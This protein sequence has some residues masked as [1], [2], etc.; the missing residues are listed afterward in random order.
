MQ[1]DVTSGESLSDRLLGLLNPIDAAN[2][3]TR[4]VIWSFVLSG[5]GTILSYGLHVFLARRLGPVDYGRYTYAMG[6][7]NIALL[8]VSFELGIVSLR[9]LGTYRAHGEWGLIRGL[10]RR[11]RTV[12]L[13]AWLVTLAL[14]GLVTTLGHWALETDLQR[15]FLAAAL[16][17]PVA[18]LLQ[19]EGKFL[20]GFDRPLEARVPFDLVRP[21]LVLGLFALIV[22]GGRDAAAWE[23]VASNGVGAAVALAASVVLF[24]RVLPP[25]VKQAEP[26]YDMG[27][28]SRTALTLFA[29][30]SFQLIISQQSDVVVVGLLRDTTKAGWYSAASQL[31]TLVG[32]VAS[33]S[34]DVA[35]A[36]IASRYA[37]GD[38]V[39][40]RH[41]IQRVSL[42]NLAIAAPILLLLVF[43]GRPLLHIYG[44]SFVIAYPVLWRLG[45]SQLIAAGIGSL[46]GVVL[47]MTGKQQLAA[48]YIMG[49]ALLNLGLT[50][51]WTPVFGMIGT[52]EATVAAVALR[53]LIV[54]LLVRRHVGVAL[55]PG[56]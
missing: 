46:G 34:G 8:V 22:A 15:A 12:I 50:L 37:A 41:V 39:G 55:R 26:A 10:L 11:S 43:A 27:N 18:A 9:F 6:W 31:A 17:L 4:G 45:L 29:I 42:L 28:W 20:Q 38:P 16:V 51:W 23:A 3:L 5:A 25:E 13:V 19:L 24:R 47:A 40:L 14:L 44:D 56:W 2:S 7:M 33:I 54:F 52:A 53:A 30:S 32:M 35:A 36:R 48:P 1:N 21:L 49:S